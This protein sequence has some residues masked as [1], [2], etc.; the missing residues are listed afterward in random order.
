MADYV[1]LQV[2]SN[3]SFLRGASHA[4]ELVQTAAALGLGGLGV[5][6]RNTLAGVVRA[7]SAA[8]VADLPLVVGCRLDLRDGPSFLCFP[9]NR[10]AYGRL[11]R[12]L[13]LGQGRA[14]KGQC[15]L[16]LE[17]VFACAKGQ[18]LVII[19]PPAVGELFQKQL[20]QIVGSLDSPPYLAAHHLYRGDDRRR[21]AELADLAS[22]T[23]TLLVGTNDVHYHVAGR[24]PLQ[25]V[26]TCIREGCTIQEAGFRLLAHAERH[27]KPGHEMARLFRGHE[28]AVARTLEIRD[29]CRFS[30]DELRYDY[31]DEPVPAGKTPQS[32]LE[33]L[34][35]QGAAQRYPGGF[36]PRC[37]RRW[38]AS[39]S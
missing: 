1:E 28:A 22:R 15:E 7:H 6:D 30:L 38:R 36:Q 26:I 13:T 32:H 21:L 18:A 14:E 8:L 33:D 31:P 25:D 39:S 37:E 2:T 4:E 23:G 11:C 10:T 19:P 35:W 9:E 5:T 29:R 17:D 20:R 3:F 27:L 34:T 16:Y 24:R 12:L